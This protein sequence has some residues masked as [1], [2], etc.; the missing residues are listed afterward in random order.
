MARPGSLVTLNPP[1]VQNHAVLSPLVGRKWKVARVVEK[2]GRKFADVG[3]NTLLPFTVLVSVPQR[4]GKDAIGK[5]L[6]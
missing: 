6:A 3:D 1:R 2:H 5:P 4:K